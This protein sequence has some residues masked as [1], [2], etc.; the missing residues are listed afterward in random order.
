M[1]LCVCLVESLNV[2]ET[3]SESCSGQSYI[4]RI[5]KMRIESSLVNCAGDPLLLSLSPDILLLV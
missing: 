4:C 5:E 3:V 1:L 2:K